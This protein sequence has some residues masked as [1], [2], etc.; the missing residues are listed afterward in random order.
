MGIIKAAALG[1][2]L[3][4]SASLVTAAEVVVVVAPGNPVTSLSETQV[5]N[6]FL[7]RSQY[8][9]GGNRA[10]PVDQA[11]GSGVREAFYRG[12]VGW[13]PAQLKS[14]W[15]RIIFTGRG[16]PPRTVAGDDKVKD[17]IAAHPDGIG[18]ISE[19]AVDDSV[20]VLEL[21]P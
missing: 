6:I 21:N 13:T 19:Q 20:K 5:A 4:L 8:F 12:L 11:E 3:L 1:A 2:T 9:P 7:G 14:H 15:S 10:R 17:F 18:Y 16:E